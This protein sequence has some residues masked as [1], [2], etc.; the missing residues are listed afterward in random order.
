MSVRRT[1]PCL[2]G[3]VSDDG[4]EIEVVVKFS[5]GCE[6][7]NF[8]SRKLPP[9]FATIPKERPIPH[10]LRGAAMEILAF[11]TFI[12][13]PDRT[14]DNPNCQSNGREFA[15]FDHE[16][17]FFMDGILGW[18]PPWER[19]GVQFPKGLP[20]KV[21]HVFLE[22]LR[23]QEVDL[24]RLMGAFEAISPARLTEY[25]AALPPTWVGDGARVDQVL[26]YIEALQ[27]NAK[28]AIQH[29]TE[30]LR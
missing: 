17:A 2:L 7:K 5:A 12:A 28:K 18:K 24:S 27:A 16:L 4:G 23:G 25:R 29:F 1:G 8:G 20:P 21:R 30:T 10:G 3:C 13:N 15:I 19:S 22:E 14:V 11:D 9:G 26:Q 6:M